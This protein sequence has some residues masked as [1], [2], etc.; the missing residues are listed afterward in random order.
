MKA[1]GTRETIRPDRKG[2]ARVSVCRGAG[3]LA[4]LPLL[5]ITSPLPNL[6]ST[7]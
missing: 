5:T 7:T 1:D 3:E 2:L 4:G 6:S